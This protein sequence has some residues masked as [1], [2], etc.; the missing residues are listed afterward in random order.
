MDDDLLLALVALV[1]S[2][3]GEEVITEILVVMEQ[4]NR[5]IASRLKGQS[6]SY[7]DS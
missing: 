7:S 2:G 6:R 4:G 1:T 5:A 3:I